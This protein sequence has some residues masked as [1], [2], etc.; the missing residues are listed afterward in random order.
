[1]PAAISCVTLPVDDL[2]A[3]VA[4][5]SKALGVAP[6]DRDADQASFDLD[7]VFLVLT[8]RGDFSDMVEAAAPKGAVSAMLSYITESK[9]E[10]DSVLA[11][12]QGAGAAVDAAEQDETIYS[13]S[14]TDPNGHVWE[15]LH[16]AA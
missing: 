13:G 10:V 12:A 14:F 3:S 9:G 5:Y 11:A 16:E 6:D 2:D 7:G 8:K 15:V 4:F 1:M